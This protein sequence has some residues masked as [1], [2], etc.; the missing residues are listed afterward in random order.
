MHT[1]ELEVVCT[2]Y[3]SKR[4]WITGRQPFTRRQFP[5]GYLYCT[6]DVTEHTH[7]IPP[8]LYHTLRVFATNKQKAD[9]STDRA[10]SE[11]APEAAG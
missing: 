3:L 1:V 8:I 9:E 10:Y 5:A 2:Q 11:N 4:K 6:L 7:V